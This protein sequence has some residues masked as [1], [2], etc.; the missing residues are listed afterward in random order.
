MGRRKR[1]L[2]GLR[3]VIVVGIVVL[4]AIQLVPFGREHTNPPVTQNA[5]WPSPRAE[6]IVGR[7]CAACH[8]NTTDWPWYSHVAPASW[9]VTLDVDAGRDELNF[10]R[11]DDDAGEADD[12]I[13]AVLDGTMPPRRYVLM[14]PSARLTEEEE[15]ILTDALRAMDD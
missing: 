2:Q 4:L 10:S 12:A 14:H 7:S 15:R 8:S 9:L 5:P 1:L 11:W 3:P 13:E 6:A